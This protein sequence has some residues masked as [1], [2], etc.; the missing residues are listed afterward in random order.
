MLTDPL[1]VKPIPQLVLTGRAYDIDYLVPK[2]SELEKKLRSSTT[3]HAV[4]EILGDVVRDVRTP[5][6][7]EPDLADPKQCQEQFESK[8]LKDYV[9]YTPDVIE[10]F[11][12]IQQKAL[13]YIPQSE[14]KEWDLRIDNLRNL[15]DRVRDPYHKSELIKRL[16]RVVELASAKPLNRSLYWEFSKKNLAWIAEKIPEVNKTMRAEMDQEDYEFVPYWDLTDEQLE[17]LRKEKVDREAA[18]LKALKG[19]KPKSE[20]DI[21]KEK[22]AFKER[23]YETIKQNLVNKV[24]EFVDAKGMIL[25]REHLENFNRIEELPKILSNTNRLNKHMKN[26]NIANFNISSF[27]VAP[28]N[29]DTLGS[30]SRKYTLENVNME[31]RRVLIRL[32]LDVPLSDPEWVEELIEG[33]EEES[34]LVKRCEPRYVTDP[35]LLLNA[36]K[37]I[38]YCQD[39]LAKSVILVGNLGPRSGE[40][41]EEFTLAPI[42]EYLQE[43]LDQN[44]VFMEDIAVNDFEDRLEELPENS[45]IIM[46]NTAFSPGEYGY[47]ISRDGVLSHTS[48]QEISAFRRLLASYCS[49]FVNECIGPNTCMESDFSDRCSIS[50]PGCSSLEIS[51]PDIECVLGLNCEKEVKGLA[52][53]LLEKDHPMIVLIGDCGISVVDRLLMIYALLDIAHKIVV[54]A[55]LAM[56]FYS[57][58]KKIPNFVH[59]T[60]YDFFIDRILQYAKEKGVEIHIPNDFILANKVEIPT[61]HPDLSQDFTWAHYVSDL[62][63]VSPT[64]PIPEDSN[65]HIIA[66]G[67]RTSNSIDFQLIES[68]KIL[69]IGNLDLHYTNR[70]DIPMI[71]KSCLE[72]LQATREAKELHVGGF[73]CFKYLAPIL[74]SQVYAIEQEKEAVGDLESSFIGSASVTDSLSGV[75]SLNISEMLD[76]LFTH[77]FNGGPL[78]ISILQGRRIRALDVISEHPKPKKKT[79]EEDTSYLDII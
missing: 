70:D 8:N 3:L 51:G 24:F 42:A 22:A 33:E 46:E 79:A 53:F 57:R 35:K 4:Q 69:W 78:F 48:L 12:Y 21:N 40:Y 58:D 55:D 44:I 2:K 60:K 37:T 5:P 16:E 11:E 19:K 63:Q 65:L 74:T 15:I 10:M 34:K 59:D 75:P 50:N 32:N 39:H 66:F 26:S 38:R 68:R 62:K 71:N 76:K 17:K 28:L 54:L 77:S 27:K 45:I 64:D 61:E 30:Y 31:G 43:E 49:V 47:S 52:D 6:P 25:A 13:R 14:A 67:P 56:L 41:R 72:F 29:E 9:W 7:P 36:V 1:L 18:K 20:D 73:E 23:F